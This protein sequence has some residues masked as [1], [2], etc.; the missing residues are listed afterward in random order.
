M[1]L[2]IDGEVVE[3]RPSEFFQSKVA[4]ESRYLEE[5]KVKKKVGRPPK[6]EN[7]NIFLEKEHGTSSS[8]ESRS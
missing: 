3:I 7:E 8:T 1:L 2:H 6:T 4:V 5:I